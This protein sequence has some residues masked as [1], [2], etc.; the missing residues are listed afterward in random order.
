MQ[1][2]SDRHFR[3]IGYWILILLLISSGSRVSSLHAQEDLNVLSTWKHYSNASDALYSFLS[4]QAFTDL[5]QRQEQVA[6][7]HTAAAWRKRQQQVKTTLQN[8]VGP[9]PKKTPLNARVV[10]TLTE[11]GYRV[12]HVVYESLPGFY[13]TASL[14][15]PDANGEKRP[16]VLFCSGHTSNGYR[17]SG[18]QQVILNLVKKG[19]VVLAFDPMGQGE[20]L[21]YYDAGMERGLLG[22]STNEHSYSGEQ[23]FLTGQSVARYF[24]WDG[25]RGIDYLVSRP[26]VD[27]DRIGCVGQSGGGTQSTFIAAFD[28]RVKVVC[29]SS[30]I[31]TYH[32]LFES[33]G[34]QDGEQ[35]IYHGIA[36]GVDIPDL[37][38]VRA[39]KPALILSTT[40][41]FFSIQGAREAYAEVQKAYQALGQPDNIQMA[42]DDLGHG[43]TQ[44]TREAMYGFL[45][46]HLNQ[47]GDPSEEKVTY[48][49]AE[50]LR[51]TQ[52]GQVLSSLGGKTISDILQEQSANE[53]RSLHQSR[54]HPARHIKQAVEAARKLSGFQMPNTTKQPVFTGRYQ[55]DGYVVEKYFIDNGNYPIPFL[56]MKP[57]GNGPFPVV[58]Y[59]HPAGKTA[60]ADPGGEMEWFVRQGNAV[61]APDLIGTGELGPGYSGG[62]IT[63]LSI[64]HAIW[65]APVQV[66]K[67]IPGIR[68]GEIMRV[69]GFVR[70]RSDLNADR[71]SGVARGSAGSALLYAA[72]FDQSIRKIALIQSPVSYESMVTN[73]FYDPAYA[74]GNVSGALTAYDL[75]DLEAALAP[76][77]LLLVNTTDQ[78]GAIIPMEYL[79]KQTAFIRETYQRAGQLGKFTVK[80]RDSFEPMDIV[81][82][83]WLQQ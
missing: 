83:G 41:D 50:D 19:F 31:T 32:R 78:T 57:A 13:V 21:Q 26:E 49:N 7:L 52:T 79:I 16:A 17:A 4:Q 6:G 14:F 80:H 59:L 30:Y 1:K 55:R 72:V 27:P 67:S 34:P 81:F 23:A 66:N 40:R 44:K 62:E 70:S 69:L 56:L 12:E 24:V 65:F 15:L 39:P 61:I 45:Q 51:V 29:P 68:A 20:R 22:G 33:I 46:K 37:L 74:L 10:R 54:Q 2:L 47:P 77:S 36:N 63:D 64:P 42:E 5:N 11:D 73:R 8:L 25:V 38:E 18:Y 76:R 60:A 48:L 53:L 35:N 75:E 3:W 82:S 28:E 9:F 58:L 43:Y 71:I